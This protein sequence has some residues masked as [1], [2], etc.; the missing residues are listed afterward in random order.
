M[1]DTIEV[2]RGDGSRRG[3]DINEPLLADVVLV[4]RGAAEMD[5]HAHPSNEVTA[6]VVFDPLVRLGKLVQLSDPSSAKVYRGKVTSISIS[7]ALP[8]IRMILGIK[9]PTE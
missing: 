4:H 5:E 8:D 2:Y 6:E 3:A 7:A 1:S 9:R